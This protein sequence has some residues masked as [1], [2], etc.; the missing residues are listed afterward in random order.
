MALASLETHTWMR[1]NPAFEAT[2]GWFEDELIHRPWS[3][4][5]H[6]GDLARSQKANRDLAH[7]VPL[8]DF[9]NRLR[10]KTGGYRWIAWD[11][12]PYTGEAFILAEGRDV[13]R[14]QRA[15]HS[16]RALNSRMQRTNAELE[17]FAATAS[18]DLQ[19]PL[20]TLSL[21][22]ELLMR[23]YQDEQ[24]D[25]AAELLLSIS[26]ATGR[27][28]A[29]VQ[30]LLEYGCIVEP[31]HAGKKRFATVSLEGVFRDVLLSLASGIRE[32][33]ARITHDPLPD[34]QGDALQLS[35]LL[36]NLLSN[37]LKYRDYERPLR[38]HIG[39]ERGCA[40]WRFQ[41]TDNG[42]GFEPEFAERIFAPF[43]RLKSQD[44]VPGSGLGLTICR[45]IMEGHGG[46]IWAESRQSEGATFWFTLP[47]KPA[48]DQTR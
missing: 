16:L 36:Q 6:P 9:K 25:G 20:R 33:R 38:I 42:A 28:R 12:V 5:V 10:C 13:T 4:I 39:V 2:L 47:A 3:E 44:E 24:P 40:E 18:H 21:Y 29:L 41:I 37:S 8:R 15:L 46:K 43:K 30:S 1:V 48:L 22:S 27:M 45:K 19:E 7:G 26:N 23:T 17:Q 31:L 35:R 14:T 32:A 34:V 11:G